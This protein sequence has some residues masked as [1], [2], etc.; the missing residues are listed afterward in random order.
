MKG[1]HPGCNYL[2]EGYC[3]KCGRFV[4]SEKSSEGPE[5]ADLPSNPWED[6]PPTPIEDIRA[7]RKLIEAEVG[8]RPDWPGLEEQIEK[9]SIATGIPKEQLLEVLRQ[10][11]RA[12]KK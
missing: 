11:L 10:L 9:A 8:Y 12:D 1:E 5:P 6:A 2:A 4:D 3:N 7:A